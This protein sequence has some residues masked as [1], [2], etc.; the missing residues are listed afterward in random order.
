[1]SRPLLQADPHTG[2]ARPADV[3]ASPAPPD[4]V[5]ATLTASRALVGLIARSLATLGD[6][7][8]T[9]QLR[10]LV[11]LSNHGPM[12]AGDL[13]EH[14]GANQSSFTRL[15]DRMVAGNLVTRSTGTV[16]RREVIISATEHGVR[17]VAD[18][19]DARRREIAAVLGRL[20]PDEQDVVRAGFELFA[21]AAGEPLADQLVVPGV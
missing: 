14:L 15:A 18:V 2:P 10:V 17:V 21:H 20:T 4:V 7:V 5:D 11:V 9:P 19:T 13:A 16:D 1:M 12:R 6:A 3:A 8:T